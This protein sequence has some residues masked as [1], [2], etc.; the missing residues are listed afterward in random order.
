MRFYA[1]AKTTKSI[2][3]VLNIMYGVPYTRYR[4]ETIVDCYYVNA[5]LE[6][7]IID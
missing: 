1:N 5:D 7:G 2:S 4:D 6:R 3:D